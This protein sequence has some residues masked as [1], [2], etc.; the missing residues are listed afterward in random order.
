MARIFIS[1]RREDSAGHTG[2]LHDRLTTRFG[3]DQVFKDIDSIDPGADF[4][5]AIKDAMASCDVVIVVIGKQWLTGTDA[6]GVRRLDNPKDFVRQE[7][8]AALTSKTR[9]IPVLVQGATMPNEEDLPEDLRA[10]AKHNAIEISDVRWDY[11]VERLVQ[12]IQKKPLVGRKVLV[13]ASVG[14]GV[15]AF[16]F[17]TYLFFVRSN[18]L[19]PD[20]SSSPSPPSIPSQVTTEATHPPIAAQRLERSGPKQEAGAD[21]AQYPIHLRANQEAPLKDFR[22]ARVYTLLAAQLDRQ[23][24]ETLL[25]K[26]R[27]R[28]L[29]NGPMDAEFGD[30]NFRLL[31]DSIPRAPISYL[32]EV[33][34]PHSAK[35]GTVE[36]TFPITAT[37]IILQIR[38]GNNIAEIPIDLTPVQL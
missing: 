6:K 20:N 11:D 8:A 5:Q 28:V 21:S 30:G 1:Y 22:A 26:F 2:R 34:Q 7:I 38:V 19:S 13:A 36:F 4:T 15:I 31:V 25:L 37:R 3:R 18:L 24:S 10:L 16:G 29:N 35:E 17:V 9:V 23:N 32:N 14:L 27:V 12:A 33:V